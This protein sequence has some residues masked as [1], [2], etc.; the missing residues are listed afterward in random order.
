M[1]TTANTLFASHVDSVLGMAFTSLIADGWS[2]ISG[3]AEAIDVARKELRHALEDA[4]TIGDI[5]SD[6]DCL[7]AA[8]LGLRVLRMVRNPDTNYIHIMQFLKDAEEGRLN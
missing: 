4:K 2:G 3:P 5:T 8:Y 1:N 6:E 7:G